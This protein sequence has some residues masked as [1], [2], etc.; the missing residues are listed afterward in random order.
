MKL[1][2]VLWLLMLICCEACTPQS[3]AG[4]GQRVVKKG[5]VAL[6]YQPA[7]LVTEAP[8]ALDIQTPA[9]WQLHKATLTGLSMDMP[10]MPL[11]FTKSTTASANIIKWQS[12]FLLG[13]CADA[14]MTWQL[15]L[16][17]KDEAGAEQRLNDEV[18]VFRR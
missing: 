1:K 17:F 15:E 2:I 12:Q 7:R 8:L 3:M 6:V 4:E 9:G 14:Q 13:A 16:I 10:M 11:F 5:S 18:V